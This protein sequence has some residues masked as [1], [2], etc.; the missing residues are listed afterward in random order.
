M[1]SPRNFTCKGT[2]RWDGLERER[3]EMERE[4][5]PELNFV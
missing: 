3:L 5:V 2:F 4:D 1:S